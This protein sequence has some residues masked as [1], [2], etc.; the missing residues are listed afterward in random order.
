M[1]ADR[2]RQQH[3]AADLPPDFLSMQTDRKRDCADCC[4]QYNRCDHQ[5][6][7]PQDDALD[8]EGSHAGVMHRGDTT[9][10]NGTSDPLSVAPARSQRYREART[11]QQDRHGERQNGQANI[12]AARNSRSERQHSDE[13]RGPDAESGG[14]GR[15]REPH[16]PHVAARFAR[17]MKQID[18]CERCQRADDGGETHKPQIMGIG[19]A[20]IDFQHSTISE[21]CPK[22]WENLSANV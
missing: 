1:A 9:G 19:D 18:R 13:V 3:G 14:Y 20:I 2:Q 7:I 4:T 11:G 8:F 12:V 10:D 21:R 22:C 16:V 15:Y 17:V 6:I 5:R